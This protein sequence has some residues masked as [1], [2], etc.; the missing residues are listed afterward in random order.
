MGAAASAG[1]A[2]RSS[3]RSCVRLQQLPRRIFR[4]Q[5]ATSRSRRRGGGSDSVRPTPTTRYVVRRPCCSARGVSPNRITTSAASISAPR[6][7]AALS[8]TAQVLPRGSSPD[9]SCGSRPASRA[10]RR[11]RHSAR[12]SP[13]A[14]ASR[15]ARGGR[16]AAARGRARSSDGRVR[17]L[18]HRRS[19]CV[20]PEAQRAA[21][22]CR[23]GAAAPSIG[24]FRGFGAAG[25][26]QRGRL[27]AARTRVGPG[28]AAQTFWLSDGPLTT[29][30]V[31]WSLLKSHRAH[32][33]T[34]AA[35]GTQ[36]WPAAWRHVPS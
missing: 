6:E 23:G 16:R 19:L 34:A 27:G 24:D 13:P 1:G 4:G 12:E 32:G 5:K 26:R 33:K 9:T 3:G 20:R 7:G 21:A 15:A 31:S 10:A 25:S 36:E 17:G 30:Y 8:T 22:M 14:A 2:K 18:H 29:H 28:R 35:N 11:G